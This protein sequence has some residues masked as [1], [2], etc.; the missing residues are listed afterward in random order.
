MGISQGWARGKQ[1][2]KH[3]C[4]FQKIFKSEIPYGVYN[5]ELHKKLFI[6][7]NFILSATD[8]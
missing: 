7:I 2:I 8:S 5:Y 6:N 4:D 3:A 1:Y